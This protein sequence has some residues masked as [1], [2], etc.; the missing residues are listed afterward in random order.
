VLDHGERLAAAV[1]AAAARAAAVA[2][3]GQG[4][5]RRGE[6]E[7][8]DE[9]QGDAENALHGV[10]PSMGVDGAAYPGRKPRV[11]PDAIIGR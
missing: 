2:A 5:H 6:D 1:A 7:D 11:K 3:R 8:P 9:R 4:A 10:P